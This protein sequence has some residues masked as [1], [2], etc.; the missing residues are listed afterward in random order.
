MGA[1]THTTLK[2]LGWCK[3]NCSFCIVEIC[4]LLL[5]YVL[6]KRGYK[7]IHHFNVH[8]LLY[9]FLGFFAKDISCCLFYTKT[10]GMMLDKKEMRVIFLFEFKM[11]REAV[12][13]TCN[14]SNSWYRSC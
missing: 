8:F 6:N 9:V 14:I 13:T 10:T 12:E 3:S 4:H 7:I 11:G 5:E 1:G 2:L